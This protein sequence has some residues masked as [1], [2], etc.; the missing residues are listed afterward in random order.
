MLLKRINKLWQLT[1]DR[2][3]RN[4]GVL[5]FDSKVDKVICPV[6]DLQH[7][8]FIRWDAKWGDAIV[9]S[10]VIA[11]LRRA[12]PEI[13]ITIVTSAALADY[14][15][16][17]LKVD[18]VIEAPRK[19]TYRQLNTL[20]QQLKPVDLLIHFTRYMKMKDLFLLYKVKARLVA[21]LDDDIGRVNLK[22]GKLTQRLH[23][24]QKLVY[25]LQCLGI[26]AENSEYHVPL[27]TEAVQRVET[28]LTG[29]ANAPLLV[30][31]P[32]GGD[33]SRRL[34]SA[35]TKKMISAI[36][37]I[38]PTINIVVLFTTDTAAEVQ[39]LCSDLA[40]DNVFYYPES[41]TIYDA[42]ALVSKADWVISVD[43][44]IVHIASGLNKPL[45][46]LYN[47]DE[48]NYVDWHPNSAKAIICFAEQVTPP[49][50]NALVW[51]NLL[52]SLSKLL[53]S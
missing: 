16:S 25:L 35:I 19:P 7:V 31:N 24:S 40:K 51:Q 8:V 47:P 1:R 46:A 9:S 38:Q 22:L 28:F 32:F 33:K 50:I 26:K 6:T 12:Y 15:E 11:P 41:R 3:R 18:Q 43:T 49:D 29:K 42:I 13:K 53:K 45:L 48:L 30:L 36:L 37:N 39:K 2:I 14:F 52:P 23:F 27:D 21:G 17:Y 20:A 10:L 4:L 5:L 44:A 34:N